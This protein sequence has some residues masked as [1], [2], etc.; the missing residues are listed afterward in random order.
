MS[1]LNPTKFHTTPE[2]APSRFHLSVAVWR[3]G[4]WAGLALFAAV[5]AGLLWFGMDPIPA[6]L[7]ALTFGTLT[8]LRV[9]MGRSLG[10][11]LSRLCF[12]LGPL[13]SYSM[14]EQMNWNQPWSSF[15]KLQVALN[16]V[17]YYLIACGLYLLLGRRNL[18]AGTALTLC[19]AIGMANRYVIR[20]RGRTI[21]PAIC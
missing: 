6:G 16:L 19:F 15:S 2:H 10:L 9:D 13:V 5:L 1:V 11:L 7:W 4:V 18:S 3:G 17:W 14:V 21:F 8:A 20:F 12:A